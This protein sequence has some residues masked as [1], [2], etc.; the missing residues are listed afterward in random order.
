[1]PAR[2]NRFSD[3]LLADIIRQ[4]EG[5]SSSEGVVISQMTSYTGSLTSRPPLRQV[6]LFEIVIAIVVNIASS[7]IYDQIKEIVKRKIQEGKVVLLEDE[8]LDKDESDDVDA[9]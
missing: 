1:M 6:E 3:R 9:E 5:G 4:I 2:E 7:A 8:E